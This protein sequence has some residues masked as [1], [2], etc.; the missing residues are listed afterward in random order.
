MQYD[1]DFV[2]RRW[3]ILRF[4]RIFL[5]LS[6]IVVTFLLGACFLFEMKYQITI[7]PSYGSNQVGTS[8]TLNIKVSK[9]G[10]LGGPVGNANIYLNVTGANPSST[11][12]TS[13]SNGKATFTYTGTNIG[14]DTIVASAFGVSATAVKL[15]TKSA[16]D[17]RNEIMGIVATFDD[18]V[19]QTFS[20]VEKIVVMG[21]EAVPVLLNLLS[22][23]NSLKVR[24]ASIY[25][26]PRIA[27][28]DEIGGAKVAL[29]DPNETIGTM[30]AAIFVGTGDATSLSILQDAENSNSVMMYSIPPILL[31]EFAN[32]VLKATSSGTRY[33]NP[34]FYG[35]SAYPLYE[36]LDEDIGETKFTV[37]KDDAKCEIMVNIYIEL[38]G[39]GATSS[40]ANTWKNGIESVWNGPNGYR[41]FGC[42][43]V[44]FNA[45][46]K[47]NTTGATPEA[48][49]D[50]IKVVSIHP[51]QTH[52]SSTVLGRPNDG[53]TNGEW[54][55]QDTGNVAAH[56]TGHLMGLDDE[57]TYDASGNYVN[58]N[59]QV[60][61]PQSIM[62]QT[63]GNVSAL[64]S[65][66]NAIMKNAGISVPAT[67]TVVPAS[68]TNIIGTEHTVKVNIR[69]PFDKPVAGV[70][71]TFTVSG[72]NNFTREAL[73]DD[74]GD[75]A[76]TYVYQDE[77]EGKDTINVKANCCLSA[78]VVKFWKFPSSD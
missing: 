72:L 35:Y 66:I 24:W 68:A 26:L 73:T 46:I 6:I 44:K 54:D 8:H 1:S 28:L 78:T 77:K 59:P 57:Y 23:S 74:N 61:D 31:S 25:T 21:D 16:T 40:L 65:H 13:D 49:R 12:L 20:S 67:M 42:Y 29:Q 62:A 41:K 45:D 50:Q 3:K 76:L 2:E 70:K 63:W 10:L 27:N 14:T 37:T 30:A 22:T 19:P 32:R 53:S 58:T 47:V 4:S 9:I 48:S 69:D 33:E 15:W 38:T 71:V 60:T 43:K 56:E 55:N 5:A 36:S 75:T 17:I 51:T 39:P 11:T 52:T 7:S 64:Q 18:G 34:R